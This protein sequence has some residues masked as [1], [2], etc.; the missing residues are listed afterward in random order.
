MLYVRNVASIGDL[1]L[2]GGLA[3]FLFATVVLTPAELQ[4]VIRRRLFDDEEVFDRGSGLAAGLAEASTLERPLVLGGAGAGLSSPGPSLVSVGS[5]AGV[6]RAPAIPAIPAI[7][8][9]ARR[10]PYVRLSLQG[11]FSALWV[12]QPISLFGDR[13]HQ[14]ALAFLVLGATNSPIAVGAVF[15]AATLPNLLFG[16]IA[17]TFVD[18]WDHRDVMVV[19]DLLRAAIVLILPVAAVTNLILV[20]PL[21]FLVTTISMFF[22]PARVALLPQIVDED[23]LLPANSAMWI[24]ET[25]ADIVGYPLAGLFVAFLGAAFPLAFWFDAASY[26]ASAV[27][28]A[29]IIVPPVAAAFDEERSEG[30]LAELREGWQ[31]LRAETVLLAN[32]LQGV[33]GQFMIGILLTLMPI[34]ARDAIHSV[35][36]GKEAIYS[37]LESGIGVGNLIGGFAVGV[38]GARIGLGKLV[39]VGYAVTGAF[40][41][42]LGAAGNLPLAIGLVFGVGVGNLIFIIP[43]QTLFQKRVPPEL[44]GRVVGFRFSLT[45]GSMTLAMAV[46]GVLGA[47]FGAPAVIGAF[48]RVTVAAGLSGLLVPAIR[49][50]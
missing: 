39:I 44:M 19:S 20:Y 13:I 8:E 18:R 28:V 22:R 23:D 40:V 16:P 26:A 14:I 34:Y 24:G 50:A 6:R 12:G 49:D 4:E 31:F 2:T 37:F 25:I 9:R 10:H 41:A 43:S 11:S 46:G 30:F 35:T 17:G 3:F 27:L 7:L 21:V 48:G 29:S 33:A 5:A 42:L 1:F 15:V 45:F 38:I 36:F 47:A 32:T